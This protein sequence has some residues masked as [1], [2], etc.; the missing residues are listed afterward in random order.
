M[1]QD[2]PHTGTCHCG[3]VRISIP[4]TPDGIT[5]CNCTLCTKTGMRCCYFKPDEVQV[6]AAPGAT[7]AY[8]RADLDETWLA[9]HHCTTCGVITHWTGLP[10][11]GLDKMGVNV[12]LFGEDVVAGVAVTEVDGRSW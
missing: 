2:T 1:T 5:Q 6:E 10:G 8:V 3:A 9:T 7:T 4:R 11:R 12:R